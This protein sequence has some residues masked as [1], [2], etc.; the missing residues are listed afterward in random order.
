MSERL[1]RDVPGLTS[2]D[3]ADVVVAVCAAAAALVLLWLALAVVVAVVD[4]LRVRRSPR[5]A[6]RLTPGVPVVVRRVVALVVG[7]LLGSAALSATAAERGAATGVPELGW[8]A[9]AP[10]AAAPVEP[11]W[12]TTRAPAPVQGPQE[13]VVQRGD[14]LWSLAERRCG[15]GAGPARVLAEQERLYAANAAVIGDDPDLLRPGVVLHLP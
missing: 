14:S 5:R 8:A 11:G 15:P 9:S 7:L 4:E 2:T 10:A 13:H 12:A 3:P 6:V 1:W